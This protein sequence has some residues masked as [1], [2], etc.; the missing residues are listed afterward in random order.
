MQS[1]TGRNTSINA[2]KLPAVYRKFL[3]DGRVVLDYGCGRYT[4][5]IRKSFADGTEYLPYDPFNQPAEINANSMDRVTELCAKHIPIDVVC[6]NVLNVIDDDEE[7]AKIASFIKKI[8]YTSGG[9]GY[10]TV[11]EGDKSGVGKQTGADQY[12]RNEPIG[13]YRNKYFPSS[14]IKRGTILI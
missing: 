6:S 14:V 5:H 7:I 8:C 13:N 1:Y 2:K 11:Y 9:C 3:F 4:D 10:V 12:Q